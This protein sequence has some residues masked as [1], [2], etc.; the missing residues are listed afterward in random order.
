MGFRGCV[1]LG[2]TRGGGMVVPSRYVV[3][4]NVNRRR[5]FG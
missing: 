1:V 2:K 4:E 5:I 3:I